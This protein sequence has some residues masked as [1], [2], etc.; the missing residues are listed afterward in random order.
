MIQD[1]FRHTDRADG[2][3]PVKKRFSPK[4]VNGDGSGQNERKTEERG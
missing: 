3:K 4:N 1:K 2:K